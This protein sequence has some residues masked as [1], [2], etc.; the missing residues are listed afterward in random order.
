MT[1]AR[2]Q[3]MASELGKLEWVWEDLNLRPLP[4]QQSAPEYEPPVQAR[5]RRSAASDQCGRARLT[6][7]AGC[8]P[9][10]FRS[11][12]RTSSPEFAACR[13]PRRVR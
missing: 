7:P 3:I 9:L 5:L 2:S 1:N 12:D 4:Y 11:Q 13:K 6:G 8:C 10:P